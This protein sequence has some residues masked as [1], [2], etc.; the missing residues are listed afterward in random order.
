MLF[1][2][3]LLLSWH[4]TAERDEGVRTLD[5]LGRSSLYRSADVYALDVALVNAFSEGGSR[6]TVA[7]HC[8]CWCGKG[9]NGPGSLSVSGYMYGC[10]PLA[11]E[12]CFRKVWR[13]FI[14][15]PMGRDALIQ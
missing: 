9:A 6:S 14:Y 15:E 12:D 13:P 2:V 4:G 10:G 7:H 3:A 5:L 11:C 1:I 8:A